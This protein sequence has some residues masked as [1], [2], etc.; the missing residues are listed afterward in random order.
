M[1]EDAIAIG[2]AYNLTVN[3]I[4]RFDVNA[5]NGI[6]F[7]NKEH[8]FSKIILGISPD[9]SLYED[10]GNT[11]QAVTEKC[12]ETVYLYKPIQPLNTIRNFSLVIAPKAEYEAGFKRWVNTI[13]TLVKQTT[14]KIHIYCEENTQK[15]IQKLIALRK[16]QLQTHFERF[17][18]WEDFLIIARHIHKDEALIVVI[19]R[20]NSISYQ[21]EFRKLP[22]QLSR[23]YKGNSYIIIYPEL[24]SHDDEEDDPLNTQAGLA[25]FLDKNLKKM[26][27]TRI[28]IK[29]FFR[30]RN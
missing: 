23:Y 9:K 14:G 18:D 27:E 4:L 11:I 17:E 13:I 20:E 2:H 16:E 26:D 8:N 21:N 6:L 5:A 24:Y 12:K 3:P 19:S 1:L 28:R 29:K 7:S 15:Q 10:F 25:S 22:R 30:K